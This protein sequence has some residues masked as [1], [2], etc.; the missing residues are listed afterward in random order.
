MDPIV[1][2]FGIIGQGG[3]RAIIGGS[4]TQNIIQGRENINLFDLVVT[5]WR[6]QTLHVL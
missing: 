1:T 5:N 6:M 3:S 4:H 2:G